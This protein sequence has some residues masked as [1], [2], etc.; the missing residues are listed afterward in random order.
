MALL[1]ELGEVELNPGGTDGRGRAAI[2]PKRRCAA[3]PSCTEPL[4]VVRDPFDFFLFIIHR[5]LFRFI[6]FSP[7]IFRVVSAMKYCDLL[8][9]S[10]QVLSTSKYV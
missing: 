7:S 3:L 5:F 1:R 8:S 4:A 10:F 6:F 2:Q 9:L